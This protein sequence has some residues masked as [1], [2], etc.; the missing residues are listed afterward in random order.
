MNRLSLE[1]SWASLWRILIMGGFVLLLYFAREAVAALLLA[2]FLSTALEPAVYRL[3]QWRIPRILGTVAVYLAVVSFFVVLLSTALPLAIVELK[4]VMG[5]FGNLA[6]ELFSFDK[7]LQTRMVSIVN[8]NL[9]KTTNFLRSDDASL[10]EMART[11][12]GGISFAVAVLVLS[13]YLS[14]S[15][16]G[17]ARFLRAVFPANL[18][19]NVLSLY[20]RAKKK[21]GYWVKAQLMLAAIVG[22]LVFLGLLLGHVKYKLVLALLAAVFEIIPIV[23][24]V[25]A[26]AVA[27]IVALSQSTGLGAYV[28][29]LFLV[30]QQVENHVLVPIVMQKAIDIHPVVILI[31]ILG[32]YQVAGIVGMLLA[33]PA[34]VVLQEVVEDWIAAKART[35]T[36]TNTTT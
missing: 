19:D 36:G 11:L 18:E 1:V 8:K 33:V 22:V 5:S 28:L 2:I 6:A 3:E 26:G 9:D 20:Y 16:D 23:G 25:L 30:V 13:F 15:R 7:E 21:I 14:A 31:T 17:V 34:A 29:F 4:G 10:V 32:G 35:K 24:P 12:L 27:V